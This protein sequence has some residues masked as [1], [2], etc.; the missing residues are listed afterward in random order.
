ML[1]GVVGGGEGRPFCVPQSGIP[2][3]SRDAMNT[4]DNIDIFW[5]L[6]GTHLGEFV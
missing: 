5:W 4:G 6:E 2:I 1:G 3:R